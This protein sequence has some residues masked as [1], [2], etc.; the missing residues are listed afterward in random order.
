MSVAGR[1]G[2]LYGVG[3][4]PGD[5]D[6]LTLKAVRVIQRTKTLIAPKS[7]GKQSLALRV[8][9]SLVDREKQEVLELGFPMQ[10][11][12]NARVQAREEAGRQI[13]EKLREGNDVACVTVGDPLLYSTFIHLSRQVTD[14]LPEVA[15]E[16]IPGVSSITACAAAA[17]IPLACEDERVALL[18][19]TSD[20]AD[21]EAILDSFDCVVVLKVSAAPARVLAALEKKGLR[22]QAVLV[23]RC[24]TPDQR[25]LRRISDWNGESLSYFSTLIVRKAS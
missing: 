17:H 13:I 14:A 18:S 19:A 8:I 12:H 10:G 16:V 24:G 5:P 22:N 3:L 2:V 20:L 15:V 25:I 21:L 9:D 6:L 1:T 23:E 4:G 11:D 7:M